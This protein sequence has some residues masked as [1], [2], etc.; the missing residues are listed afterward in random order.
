MARER[1]VAQARLDE[2]E[3]LVVARAGRY[4]LRALRIQPFELLLE[5]GELEE[6]VLLPLARQ[7]DVMDRAAVALVDFVVGLE[8]GALGAVPALV[9]A[10]VDVAVVAHLGEDVL[11]DRHVLRIGG[12]DEEVVGGLD[13]GRERLETLGVAI[14]ELLRLDAERVGGVGDRLAVLVGAGQEEHLLAA[15]AVMA[16]DHVGGDRRVRVPQ[17]RRRVDVVDRGGYVER[18]RSLGR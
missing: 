3:R 5:G 7:L 15:L 12:A 6:V 9:G 17:M 2:R 10:H 4:E 11:H 14:R 18:H 16:R 13:P 8:V 1:H